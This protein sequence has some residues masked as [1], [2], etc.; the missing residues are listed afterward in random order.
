MTTTAKPLLD[1]AR[2]ILDGTV[3]LP[4]S[5]APRAAAFLVRQA[6]EET[7]RSLCREAGAGID[8]A[9]MRSILIVLRTLYGDSLADPMNVAW[10]G[11]C[12]ACHHHAY[13]LAPTAKEVHHLLALV[14]ELGAGARAEKG[15]AGVGCRSRQPVVVRH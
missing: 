3:R 9:S 15:D 4:G 11:L 7:A 13:E 5:I 1:H 12:N 2:S 14:T 8:R 6:L 10:T